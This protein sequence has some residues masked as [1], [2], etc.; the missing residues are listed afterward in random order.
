MIASLSAASAI[1]S[2]TGLKTQI[3][4]PNDILIKGKKVAGI[5]IENEV[6]GGS[7]A[8]AI[9]GIG[10]NVALQPADVAAISTIATGLEDETGEKVS[11]E[12]VIRNLF[13][14]FERLYLQLPD[15][16][17]IFKAWRDRLITLEQKVTATWGKETFK[18]IAESVDESGA[19]MI[20]L[21]DGSLTTVVA[22]DVTLREK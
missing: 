8:Y 20:R 2:T 17:S 16:T 13:T 12:D 15:G 19:L 6:K 22:G 4:W 18:G 14:E 21:S 10:I 11:R 3:K 1:E 5:L 9:I 7:V